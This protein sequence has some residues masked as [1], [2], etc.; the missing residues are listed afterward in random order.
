MAN[1]NNQD[2]V[3]DADKYDN[4]VKGPINTEP[5]SSRGLNDDDEQAGSVYSDNLR[6][7]ADSQVRAS[8]DASLQDD[9]YAFDED[10]TGNEDIHDVEDFGEVD[11][12]MFDSEDLQ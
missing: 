3:T 5:L 11:S 4:Q 6:S 10:N 12:D 1:Q 7:S 8:E 9:T 2:R